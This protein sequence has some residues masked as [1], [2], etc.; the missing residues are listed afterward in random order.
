MLFQALGSRYTYRKAL[1]HL[2]T[3]ATRE[4]HKRL[5]GYLSKRFGGE[6]TLYYK[7]RAAL[8]EAIRLATGGSGKVAITGFTC[9]SVVQAVEAAGCSPVYI[10]IN[11]N[12][13]NFNTDL[14]ERAL[15][16]NRI[17]CVVVQNTLG[18]TADISRIRDITSKNNAA[19]VED[20][21]HS[22]GARYE[23]GSEVGTVGDFVML[24]FG[25]DK[26]IDA[27]GGGALIV[28]NETVLGKPKQ[29]MNSVKLSQRF[30]DRIY[31]ILMWHVRKLYGVWIGKV[32]LYLAYKLLL[33]VRSAD[34]DVNTDE[35][36]PNWLAKRALSE[37]NN[38]E[39]RRAHQL[40]AVKA[41]A[42]V[43]PKKMIVENA[44]RPKNLPIRLPVYVDNREQ[45]LHELSK[46]GLF[47]HDTWYDRPIAPKRFYGL[48][49]Y[50]EGDC[51]I[52]TEVARTIIN[53]PIHE[54]V[55]PGH[56]DKIA[57]IIQGD[58]R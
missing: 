19:L 15:D 18:I 50:P 12:D 49:E 5:N 41:Y 2:F 54:R 42:S 10:D 48:V 9:Y 11:K 21:A 3:V 51:P 29:P 8:A 56:I 24:S 30:R 16:K 14:L 55:S 7:G 33:A 34:G 32:L 13:L 28:R 53:L 40:E 47:L 58:E 23:D 52:A 45:I 6:A 20:L 37:I 36:L 17:K 46:A 25:R 39:S 22:F 27:G 4:D 31:P 44:L 26:S 35:K 38:T 57:K 43:I 1:G